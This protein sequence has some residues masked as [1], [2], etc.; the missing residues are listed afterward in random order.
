MSSTCLNFC[1][2]RDSLLA[3]LRQSGVNCGGCGERSIRLRPALVFQP[4]HAHIFIDKLEAILKNE[5]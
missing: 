2:R 3:K 5:K 4:K 1:V